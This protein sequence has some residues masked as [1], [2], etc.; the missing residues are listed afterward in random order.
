MN[1]RNPPAVRARSRCLIDQA[2]SGALERTQG[3][4][5]IG[6]HVRDMVKTLTSL[7]KKAGDRSFWIEGSDQF[8]PRSAR[9]ERRHLDP[10]LLQ[11][12]SFA[13]AKTKAPLPFE[14]NV[15]VGDNKGDVMQGGIRGSQ[16]FGQH[17]S[18]TIG[19]LCP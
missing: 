8:D 15:K 3:R 5:E 19:A 9:R 11:H 12:E 14:R 18:A 10:L 13:D 16:R 6:Y 7:R 1:E 4:I 17:Q 2:Y